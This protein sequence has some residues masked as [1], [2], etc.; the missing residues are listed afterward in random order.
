MPAS[1]TF[2]IR[3]DGAD[4]RA[5]RLRH[6]LSQFCGAPSSERFSN[7]LVGEFGEQS[8]V[9]LLVEARQQRRHVQRKPVDKVLE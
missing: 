1:R 3:L 2:H 4:A 9:H 5:D 7:Y 6:F 8:V